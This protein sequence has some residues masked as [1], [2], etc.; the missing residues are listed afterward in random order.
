MIYMMLLS[1]LVITSYT[2][3][4]C[5]RR[6]GVPGSISASYYDL[7]RPHWFTAAMWLTA[8]LLM[9]A[10][11]EVSR[12]GTEYLAF[13]ACAGMLLVGS[14]PNFRESFEG[15]VHMAGAIL[16]VAGSQLWVALN[17]PWCLAAWA[18]YVS[19]TVAG[20]LGQGSG[21]LPARFLRTKP[22][23]WVEITALAAT[24]AAVMI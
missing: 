14:A 17:E 15:R 5:A 11:L 24:Y 3:V 12:A 1:L 16:C 22:M 23:F 8:G 2:A 4:I 20:M 6:N 10:V 9:P 13:L 18:A 7:K 19:C 21:N